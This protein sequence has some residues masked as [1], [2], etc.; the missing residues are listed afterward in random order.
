MYGTVIKHWLSAG[1]HILLFRE[2]YNRQRLAGKP[3]GT[4]I[5]WERNANIFHVGVSLY[6]LFS[7]LLSHK[8]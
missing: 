5:I 4:T 2:V 3:S 6:K 1:K 8:T 7:F